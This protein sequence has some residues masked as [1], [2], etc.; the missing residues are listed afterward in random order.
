MVF[1]NIL[2]RSSSLALEDD[3][4][5]SQYGILVPDSRGRKADLIFK[6]LC[7]S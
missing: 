4:P 1:L 2:G 7:L 3:S 6:E 5:C